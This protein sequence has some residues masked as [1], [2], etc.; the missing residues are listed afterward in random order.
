[1]ILRK[2]VC[3][4]DVEMLSSILRHVGLEYKVFP[5]EKRQRE[6]NVFSAFK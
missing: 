6:N 5:V 2:C 1:M 3:Y 4:Y